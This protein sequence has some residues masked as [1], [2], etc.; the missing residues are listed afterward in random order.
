MQHKVI[1]RIFRQTIVEYIAS[2]PIL[3]GITIWL[4]PVPLS[5][6]FLVTILCLYMLGI[7]VGSF[8]QKKSLLTGSLF[9]IALIHML[10][11]DGSLIQDIG[12][13][14][15]SGSI[16]IRGFQYSKTDWN[17]LLPVHVLWSF[18][19]PLYFISY[20]IYRYTNLL[21][22]YVPVITGSGL[23][24]LVLL[25][26]K[27]NADHLEQ[28]ILV[29]Q[30]K[31]SISS[32]IRKQNYVYIVIMLVI[33]TLLT[34]FGIV[35]TVIFTT[36]RTMFLAISDFF[37]LFESDSPAEVLVSDVPNE[38]SFI[39]E[40]INEP[41]QF[42]QILEIVAT[43]AVILVLILFIIFIGYRISNSFQ[44]FIH[45]ITAI[46]YRMIEIIGS[47]SILDTNM[48][49]H[50]DEKETLFDWNRFRS[51]IK[52][53]T[54]RF[55]KKRLLKQKKWEALSETEK[56]R[57]LY[58]QFVK[59]AQEEGYQVM[60]NETAHELLT[61]IDKNELLKKS[62]RLELDQLYNRAR[63]SQERLIK[64]NKENYQQ[65]LNK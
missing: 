5:I 54:N 47:K 65:L 48:S 7:C 21:E 46:I 33:I 42:A 63:Y 8:F 12:L 35:K 26:F 45:W 40:E 19:V 10:L 58:L 51:K 57:Y 41:S 32:V 38:T 50:Q 36:I 3:L 24:F 43:I 25:L 34:Q 27:S 53:Q 39:G 29:N 14:L 1:F 61:R 18:G 52:K 37:S 2:F 60:N 20:F 15:F 59:K 16:L 31:K 23:I 56:V 55:V 30:D 11:Y 44:R 6:P 13:F 28:A 4:V 64:L 9:S 49:T 62:T 22:V 17:V